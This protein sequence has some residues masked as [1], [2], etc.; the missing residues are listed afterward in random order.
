M[1]QYHRA[2][3]AFALSE[4][5]AFLVITLA[6]LM[7]LM[8]FLLGPLRVFP[9]QKSRQSSCASNMKQI[10]L[11]LFAY[12]EDFDGRLPPVAAMAHIDTVTIHRQEKIVPATG[13]RSKVSIPHILIPFLK[14]PYIFQ[15]PSASRP[16]ESASFLYNDLAAIAERS[17]FTGPART[18]L[19]A[20]SEDRLQNVGHAK[21]SKGEGDAAVF[22][23]AQRGNVPKLSLGVAI[24]NASLRHDG[25]AN[26]LFA[27]SH[28]KWLKP[29]DVFFP[30]RASTS[31]S[32]RDAKT[33]RRLGPDVAHQNG[34]AF[35]GNYYRATFHVR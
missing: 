8:I 10:G 2:D 18:I 15:C 12:A 17:D 22:Q 27:D 35:Q 31:R 1:M 19:A 32:H 20:E 11:A 13:N 25:G 16:T 24:G 23:K 28:V 3:R 30:P 6:S 29:G 5:Q 26:Y 33:G 4:K 21:S 9:V 7:G 14:N 34:M